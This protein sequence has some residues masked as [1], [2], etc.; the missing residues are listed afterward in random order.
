[1]TTRKFVC[2][3][4]SKYAR[5]SLSF[6]PFA[7]AP[8]TTAWTACPCLPPLLP[9]PESAFDTVTAMTFLNSPLHF[10]SHLILSSRTF[11]WFSAPDSHFVLTPSTAETCH[12]FSANRNFESQV[13][14]SSYEITGSLF[15]CLRTSF[16]IGWSFFS[17]SLVT[18]QPHPLHHWDCSCPNLPSRLSKNFPLLTWLV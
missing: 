9:V 10:P 16:P 5:H 7:Q 13:R 8:F 2:S 17:F 3:S 1:L 12:F 11:A 6:S 15:A 18:A 4:L 14:L